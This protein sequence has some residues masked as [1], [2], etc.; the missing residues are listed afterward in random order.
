MIKTNNAILLFFK[1]THL[2]HIKG[3]VDSHCCFLCDVDDDGSSIFASNFSS[4]FSFARHPVLPG[5][6]MTK[7]DVT[8]E[9][10]AKLL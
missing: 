1:N 8:P 7:T 3:G 4:L 2:V 6:K 5:N 9:V 10:I